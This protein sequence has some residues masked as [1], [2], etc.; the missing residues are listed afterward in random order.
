MDIYK[1][2]GE[3]FTILADGTTTTVADAPVILAGRNYAGYGKILNENTLRLAE[4]F[5]S[6]TPPAGPILGQVWFD[7]AST[8][9]RV[10]KGPTVGWK[11]FAIEN[12]GVETPQS[13]MVGDQWFD[14]AKDQLKIFSG[15]SWKVIAPHYE[16]NWGESGS[17]PFTITDV[18]GTDHVCVKVLSGGRIMMIVNQDGDFV[19]RSE[20]AGFSTIKNGININTAIP[21]YLFHGTA[22]NAVQLGSRGSEFYIRTDVDGTIN[23]DLTVAEQLHVGTGLRM[24]TSIGNNNISIESVEQ[25]KD[26]DFWINFNGTQTRAL[27]IKGSTGEVRIGGS[28]TTTQPSTEA[29]VAHRGYVTSIRSQIEA[30]RQQLLDALD[31]KLSADIAELNTK[32]IAIQQVNDQQQVDIRNI[33][34]TLTTKAPIASPTFV[35]IIR[36][37]QP[38]TDANDTQIP[39]TEWVRA[40]NNENFVALQNYTRQED[41]YLKGWATQELTKY[42]PIV[43][44][45]FRGETTTETPPLTDN[46]NR[47]VNA[48]WVKS[49][50]PLDSHLWKGSNK[51]VSDRPPT[52][53]EGVD[54]D[55][56]F[57]VDPE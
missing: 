13:P 44:A 56:W 16:K 57:V 34:T 23:A 35:G 22:Q 46:S 42:A 9:L 37:E 21:N 7:T 6:T 52:G 25:G 27:T 15:N 11:P 8:I 40:R 31:S 24:S 4:N 54:G 43:S 2:N 29:G 5:A 32:Q 26:I 1:S 51:F 30:E 50:Y 41:F 17:L 39:T 45:N 49:N 20:I 47:I 38:S 33:N 18:N 12:V 3:L 14:T 36:A 55:F 53:S 10:Y 28:F 19:P 48:Q